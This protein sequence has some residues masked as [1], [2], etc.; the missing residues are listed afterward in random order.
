MRAA[1]YLWATLSH[2]TGRGT[3]C[4]AGGAALTLTAVS[5]PPDYGREE[6]SEWDDMSRGED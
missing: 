2:G 5:V 4:P 6:G 3:V 1:G